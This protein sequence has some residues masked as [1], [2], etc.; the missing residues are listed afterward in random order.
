MAGGRQFAGTTQFAEM[1]GQA[2]YDRGSVALRNVNIGAGRLNAGAS[3]D[4]AD[5]GALS[6]R[7]VVDLRVSDDTRRATLIIGGTLKEPQLRN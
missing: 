1:N 4:I 2:T 7:I 3:A 6:G 5:N